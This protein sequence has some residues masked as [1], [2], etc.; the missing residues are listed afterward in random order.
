[1]AI[2]YCLY[3]RKFFPK[4]KNLKFKELNKDIWKRFEGYQIIKPQPKY[5]ISIRRENVVYD[6]KGNCWTWRKRNKRSV[7]LVVVGVNY[8][9]GLKTDDIDNDMP[10]CRQQITIP[11][12]SFLS[13][14]PAQNKHSESCHRLVYL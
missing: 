1:M 10:H 2:N 12:E 3:L 8:M 14:K 7:N 9:L 6:L 13:M 4:S 5:S 11:A